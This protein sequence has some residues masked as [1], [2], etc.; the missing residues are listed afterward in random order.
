[1]DVFALVMCGVDEI[2]LQKRKEGE[3]EIVQWPQALKNT[4]KFFAASKSRIRFKANT[5]GNN[6]RA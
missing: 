5:L 3:V 1:M 6:L 4:A 2:M